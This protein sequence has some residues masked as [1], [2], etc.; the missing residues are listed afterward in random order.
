MFIKQVSLKYE[1]DGLTVIE[2][3]K[4]KIEDQKKELARE[5]VLKSIQQ[6]AGDVTNEVTTTVIELP[7]DDIKGK[8]IGKE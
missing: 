1:S 4:K 8:L 7:S 5:I 2:K 6:F 3:Y